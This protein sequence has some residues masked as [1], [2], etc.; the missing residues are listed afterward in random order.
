MLVCYINLFPKTYKIWKTVCIFIL[1]LEKMSSYNAS[2]PHCAY[3]FFGSNF[4]QFCFS[5]ENLTNFATLFEIFAK[6]LIS[7]N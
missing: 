1:N 6:F 2:V 4:G 7:K 3:E 5:S